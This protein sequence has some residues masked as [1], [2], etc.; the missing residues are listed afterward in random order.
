MGVGVAFITQYA[1]RRLGLTPIT[2]DWLIESATP[3]S[4]AALIGVGSGGEPVD[5]ACRDALGGSERE[6]ARIVE[7][8][9]AFRVRRLGDVWRCRTRYV[10][11]VSVL[12]SCEIRPL[13]MRWP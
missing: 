10:A 13:W 5:D 4:R 8:R 9:V 12:K 6:L 2:S 11:T 1:V 3:L 7:N